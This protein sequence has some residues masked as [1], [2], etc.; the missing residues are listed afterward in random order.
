LN[1]GIR[2][3][4]AGGSF[5]INSTNVFQGIVYAISTSGAKNIVV[6]EGV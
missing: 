1:K 4:A 3:N 6:M 5:E 2:L